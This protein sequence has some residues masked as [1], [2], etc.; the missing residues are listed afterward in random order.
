MCITRRRKERE[1]DLLVLY[2]TTVTHSLEWCIS[3]SFVFEFSWWLTHLHLFNDRRS[4]Q[5][6]HWRWRRIIE[7]IWPNDLI[8]VR[9]N[10]WCISLLSFCCWVITFTYQKISY[11]SFLVSFQFMSVQKFTVSDAILSLIKDD[12]LSN[13]LKNAIC[14]MVTKWTRTGR[15]R[16]L[17]A[18]NLSFSSSHT[19]SSETKS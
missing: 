10:W 5:W 7:S 19:K 4:L 14:T 18:P 6:G 2:R 3:A 17:S 13:F 11:Y 16:H 9:T 8:V 1:W 15:P 12:A